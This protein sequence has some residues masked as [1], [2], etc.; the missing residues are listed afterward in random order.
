MSNIEIQREFVLVS[1]LHSQ[2]KVRDATRRAEDIIR[3]L[4]R[5]QLGEQVD[6]SCG[7]DIV[8]SPW[9]PMWMYDVWVSRDMDGGHP[10]NGYPFFQRPQDIERLQ[11]SLPIPVYCCWNG[12]IAVRAN[13]FT[14]G[15]R[16]R[17]G[18]TAECAAAEC[19]LFCKDVWN[20]GAGNIVLDPAVVTFYEHYVFSR[21]LQFGL[22]GIGNTSVPVETSFPEHELKP[23]EFLCEPMHGLG[24]EAGISVGQKPT[25]NSYG[26]ILASISEALDW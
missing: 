5:V 13:V 15:V 4:L 7:I 19:T 3:L 12:L 17:S 8:A 2:G 18:S 10:I 6:M 9:T 21:F 11:N 20:V 26:S 1:Q 24:S 16:F 23:K 14:Q 22:P 25:N